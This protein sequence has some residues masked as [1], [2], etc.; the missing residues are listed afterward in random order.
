MSNFVR[1]PYRV[2]S[3]EMIARL[4]KAGYLRPTQRNN[5]DAITAAII[6]MKQNLKGPRDRSVTDNNNDPKT[7]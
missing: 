7:T 3:R 1:S 4:V 5:A 6:K 2:A